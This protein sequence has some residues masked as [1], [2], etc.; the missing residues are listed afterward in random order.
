MTDK[1]VLCGVVVSGVVSL[2]DEGTQSRMVLWTTLATDVA[3]S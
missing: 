1:A 3:D 2:L